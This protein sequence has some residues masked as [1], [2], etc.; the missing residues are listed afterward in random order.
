VVPD[1]HGP[2]LPGDVRQPA[3]ECLTAQADDDH[4]A[5]RA[6]EQVG[7]DRERLAVLP[8]SEQVHVAHDQ[9][10]GDRSVV[11]PPGGLA[12]AGSVDKIAAL[13]AAV[14][15]ATVIT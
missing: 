14:C 7:R 1:R 13:P 3:A 8:H 12:S 5:R 6:G 4:Q 2:L 9:G 10:R 15:T 11:V